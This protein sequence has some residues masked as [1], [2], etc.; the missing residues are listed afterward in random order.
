M[1]KGVRHYFSKKSLR[2]TT[3]D[4][5]YVRVMTSNDVLLCIGGGGEKKTQNHH[6]FNHNGNLN[7]SQLL[8]LVIKVSPETLQ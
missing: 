7:G 8:N 4:C 5:R 1:L 3:V 2:V 6:V